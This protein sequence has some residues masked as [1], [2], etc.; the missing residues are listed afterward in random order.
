MEMMGD[1]I[2]LE[3]WRM[4]IDSVVIILPICLI[5]FLIYYMEPTT[6]TWRLQQKIVQLTPWASYADIY[7]CIMLLYFDSTSTVSS[8][9]KAILSIVTLVELPSSL[10]PLPVISCGLPYLESTEMKNEW[11]SP[12]FFRSSSVHCTTENW[13]KLEIVWRAWMNLPALGSA[14]S[15]R[16]DIDRCCTVP[17]IR[18]YGRT[19]VQHIVLSLWT[20]NSLFQ[21]TLRSTVRPRTI[22]IGFQSKGRESFQTNKNSQKPQTW[23]AR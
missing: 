7:R 12:K 6:L 4:M 13:G 9:R 10:K 18:S 11:A 16:S 20:T 2:L 1:D 15:A 8:S 3:G 5:F 23:K 22:W 19:D 21:K 17:Y 14:R